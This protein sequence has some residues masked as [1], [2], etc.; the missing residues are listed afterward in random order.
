MEKT[1]KRWKR[2][3]RDG[4]AIQKTLERK[5]KFEWHCVK[6]DPGS[7]VPSSSDSATTPDHTEG[8]AAPIDNASEPQM[9]LSEAHLLVYHCRI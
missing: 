4:K 1:Q 7:G 2:Y 9:Q 5:K 6:Q 3:R 8:L